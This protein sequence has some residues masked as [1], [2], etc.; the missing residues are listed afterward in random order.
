MP[1]QNRQAVQAELRD[2]LS[3]M[4]GKSPQ[5]MLGAIASS[6]LIQSTIAATAATI[7]AVVILT[8]V[9]FAIGKLSGKSDRAAGAPPEA[10]AEPAR[11]PAPAP[12]P[13][14]DMGTEADAIEK[15]GIGESESAPTNVNPLEPA[16]DDLL[17]GL[18]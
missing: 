18:E 12:E 9:P 14:I 1:K 3:Q 4:R 7:A 11:Q 16:T 2:F 5:E 8:L 15:L 17:E 6:N 13:E 10:A